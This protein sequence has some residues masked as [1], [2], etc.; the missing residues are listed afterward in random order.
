LEAQLPGALTGP[1]D[2]QATPA[3]TTLARQGPNT[4]TIVVTSYEQ[5]RTLMTDRRWRRQRA[6]AHDLVGPA[7]AMSVTEMDPPRHS[8]VRGLVGQMFS[9]RAIRSLRG[10][11]QQRAVELVDRMIHAG[12]PA[13]LVAMFCAPF[14]FAVQCDLLGVPEDARNSIHQLSMIRSGLSDATAQEIYDA[15]VALQSEVTGALQ[16]IRARGGDGVFA[17]LIEMYDSAVLNA[18]EQTGLASSLLFDGHILASSQI[19]NAIATV[20]C[21]PATP[22]LITPGRRVEPAALEELLR[23]SP[24]ITLGMPRTACT[25]L[26]IGKKTV[27]P[28]QT[29]VVAFGLVNRDPGVFD[30]PNVLDL[31]RDPNRHLAFGYGTHYCL[32]AYLARLE[33]DVAVNT[34]LARLPKLSLCVDERDLAWSASH[35]I[36]RLLSLPVKWE[37]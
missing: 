30:Q 14:T 4:A 31:R 22:P 37:G 8:E 28:G 17:R 3:K 34:L 15:E 32:G 11:V 35:T 23:W 7:S 9:P 10:R 13:D 21:Y 16:H 33:L 25:W 19:A 6:G 26:N 24:A 18:S 36:R 20:L 27:K 1:I 29:A 2:L 5:A 12:G